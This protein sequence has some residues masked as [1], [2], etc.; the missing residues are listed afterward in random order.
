MQI[1]TLLTS[2]I[3]ALPLA[4]QAADKPKVIDLVQVNGTK[5][6]NLDLAVF[7]AQ[8]T[9]GQAVE[10][11][12][13]Q[14]AMLEELV[15]IFMLAQSAEGKKL[16]KHREI[17][18]ALKVANAR[19]I[20][21]TLIR[22]KMQETKISEQAI[23]AA[24][25]E[26]YVK[27]PKVEYKARHIL[28]KTEAEA[29]ATIQ[30]LDAGKDFTALAKAKSTGP[31]KTVGGDLGW[32]N[33]QQMVKPFGDALAKMNKNTYSKQPVKTQYGW[34]VVLLEDTRKTPTPELDQVREKLTQYLQGQKVGEHIRKIRE[35]SKIKIL[36]KPPKK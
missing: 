26:Q 9:G 36:A 22:K 31:S 16:K 12:E 32:F 33:L 7:N 11:P 18:A 6:N 35:K 34:H 19:L 2:L 5:V 8:A 28:L 29:K 10:S 30:E 25:Q 14:A 21:E 24:Y 13:Q 15:N 20:A 3:V 4:L 1:K 23:K 17:A 27:G